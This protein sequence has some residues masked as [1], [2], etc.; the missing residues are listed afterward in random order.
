MQYS[1]FIFIAVVIALFYIL[2]FRPQQQ[3]AKR[4]REMVE[5]LTPGTEI[6]TIGGLFATIV[7]IDED[8]I[9]VETVDGSQVEI[10]P[11]AVSSTIAPV[12]EA[13]E[14]VMDVDDEPLMADAESPHVEPDPASADERVS[15]G[16]PT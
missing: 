4:Q 7:A 16:S 11:Q 8:R 6:M 1:N 15:V 3:Q 5:S 9:R 14:D 10:A 13:D 12:D 2:F